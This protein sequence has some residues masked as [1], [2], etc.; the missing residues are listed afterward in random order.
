MYLRYVIALATDR[1]ILTA[2]L[3]ACTT[4]I[5][6]TFTLESSP[7]CWAILGTSPAASMMPRASSILSE[8]VNS[9]KNNRVVCRNAVRHRAMICLIH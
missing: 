5:M 4:L 2:V 9:P 7:N 8:K 3:V 6:L 1:V